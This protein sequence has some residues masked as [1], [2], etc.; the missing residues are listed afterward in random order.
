[1]DIGSS[2]P[3]VFP[4]TLSIADASVREGDRG[5][6][7][8]TLTVTRSGNSG[9]QVTVQ[10]RTADGTASSKDDYSSV[11]GTLTFQPAQTS[12]IIAVPVKGDR[13]REPNETFTVKLSSAVGAT[14][15]SAVATVTILNDD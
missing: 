13:K 7:N 15:N 12:R 9:V 14:I 10:Y 3:P 8:L 11:G 2:E 5:T 4:P 6:T 1:V